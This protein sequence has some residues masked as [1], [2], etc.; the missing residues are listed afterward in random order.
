MISG[1]GNLARLDLKACVMESLKDSV[2]PNVSWESEACKKSFD[3]L[4]DWSIQVVAAMLSNM[5]DAG[6]V[7]YVSGKLAASS[8]MDGVRALEQ[9]LSESYPSNY[10]RRVSDLFKASVKRRLPKL[11]Q[12]WKESKNVYFGVSASREK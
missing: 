2:A 3:K 11:H 8:V 9:V 10:V 12:A 6:D 4:N 5:R 7:P 1:N